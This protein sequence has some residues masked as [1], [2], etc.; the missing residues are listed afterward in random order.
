[1]LIQGNKYDSANADSYGTEA[2]W[3]RE[4][5]VAEMKVWTAWKDAKRREQGLV[6]FKE[7]LSQ[8]VSGDTAK[9]HRLEAMLWA[10]TACITA[11]KFLTETD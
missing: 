6:P 3:Q 1:M 4:V 10:T 9:C 5:S 7:R 2:Y 8:T 11:G